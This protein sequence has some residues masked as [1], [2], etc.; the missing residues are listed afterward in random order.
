MAIKQNPEETIRD[1]V[2]HFNAATLEVQDLNDEWAIQAFI[3]GVC[4]KYLKYAL[5]DAQP[6]KLYQLYEKAQKYTDAE[7]IEIAN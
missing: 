6:R 4:H 2:K 3:A 1:Y 5:I 7:A